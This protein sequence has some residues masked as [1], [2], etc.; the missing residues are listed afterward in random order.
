MS[1][2]TTSAGDRQLGVDH[3]QTLLPLV[4]GHGGHGQ[5][6]LVDAS[7]VH[8]GRLDAQMRHHLAGD[9]REPAEP[10]R[11]LEEAVGIQVAEVARV[12]PA[13]LQDLRRRLRPVRGSL[14]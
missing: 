5:G 11:D 6:H 8:Q 1:F 13:V 2:L 4:V 12:V 10:T 14:A 3:D 7:G 9:L